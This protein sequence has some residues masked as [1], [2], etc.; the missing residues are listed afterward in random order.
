MA[1]PLYTML[2]DTFL[3]YPCNAHLSAPA[4]DGGDPPSR[5]GEVGDVG[6]DAEPDP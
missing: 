1:A 4:Y 3:L 6:R 5:N 2:G